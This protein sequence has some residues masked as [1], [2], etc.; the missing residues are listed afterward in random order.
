MGGSINIFL[1][2]LK[3][4]GD[5]CK[6]NKRRT[7]DLYIYIYIYIGLSECDLILCISLDFVKQIL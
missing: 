2:H 5:G 1:M 4:M 6:H 3:L 7:L